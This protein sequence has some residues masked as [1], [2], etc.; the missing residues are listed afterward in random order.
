[1][2]P[3]LQEADIGK[4]GRQAAYH[5]CAPAIDLYNQVMLVM[6]SLRAQGAPSSR[7]R[8]DLL[9]NPTG[10]PA[11]TERET[12]RV[13]LCRPLARACMEKFPDRRTGDMYDASVKRRAVPQEDACS[14][15][16]A[17]S[18]VSLV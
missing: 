5:G 15:A 17:G 11:G 1:M 2:C 12:L 7:L 13:R 10:A 6:S 3:T 16:L 4:K 18:K 14:V 8:P 9:S